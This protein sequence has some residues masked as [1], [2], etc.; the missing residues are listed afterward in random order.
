MTLD[1]SRDVALGDTEP[2]SK[3]QLISGINCIFLINFS[4]HFCPIFT[5][6]SFDFQEEMIDYQS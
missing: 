5:D 1:T 3:D 6:L 2:G 4:D